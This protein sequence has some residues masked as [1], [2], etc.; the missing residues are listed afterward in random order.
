MRKLFPIA[1]FHVLYGLHE[2]LLILL[3][4]CCRE[5]VAAS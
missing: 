5:R 3:E 4:R 1:Q 2:S